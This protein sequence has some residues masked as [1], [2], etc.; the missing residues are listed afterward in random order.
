MKQSRFAVIA[1]LALGLSVAVSGCVTPGVC[2]AIGWIN[3]VDVTLSGF[4]TAPVSDL[5]VCIEEECVDGLAWF[6]SDL[7][8][9]VATA[10]PT[11]LPTDAWTPA[12][13]G[14]REI[15]SFHVNRIADDSF[16]VSL[17][18]STP[19]AIT[20]RAMDAAGNVVASKNAEPSWQRSE[21]SGRCG[22]PASTPPIIL[23]NPAG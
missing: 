11:E 10:M 12:P 16:T 21:G 9:R 15:P 22:G 1:V 20:V 2:S 19:V 23:S 4:E 17:G 3:S 14:E 13:S 18:M 6:A 5:Q 7:P 8:L